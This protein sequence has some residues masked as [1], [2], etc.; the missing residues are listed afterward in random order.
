VSSE[1]IHNGAPSTTAG[2]EQQM[3]SASAGSPRLSMG[4]RIAYAVGGVPALIEQRG[5]SAFLLIFY[6]QVVG[7][8][9]YLVTSALLVTAIVDALCDP[10]VGQVSDNLHSRWGRRHPFIYA[11]FIPLSLGYLLIWCPPAHWSQSMVFAY[12]L[13]MLL[14]VR[15]ADSCYE[16]PA[17]ALLPELTR[18]YNER[19]GI[20][21]L[22]M[23]FALIGGMSMTML[24]YRVF[25]KEDAHGAGGIL[26]RHGY[27]GYGVASA[28][29]IAVT[30]VISGIGTHRRIPFLSKPGRR[31]AT[32]GTMMREVGTTISNRSFLALIVAGI[33]MSTC[34][35]AK[36][37]LDIYFGL[38]FWDLQQGQLANLVVASLIGIVSGVLLAPPLARRFG[39][40][41]AA[42]GV[43]IA[44]IIGNG[45]PVLG[46]LFGLMPPNHSNALFVILFADGAFTF[47]V[48]T[49]TTILM[50]SMLNDVVEDVEVKTGRRS[51]GLLMAADTLCRKLVSSLGIFI[52]GLMLT[53]IG[54]P[55]K[56]AR[57]SVAP[58]LVG[59]LAY[60]YILMTVLF[61][62][63]LCM[64]YF[65]R[66]N[67]TTHEQNLGVLRQR[68]RE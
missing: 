45:G 35:G 42:V 17:S 49:A 62:I 15:V 61:I 60:A 51:E 33:L 10:L 13:A 9:P 44:G 36:T 12:L 24:A 63:A 64:L 47:C 58:E 11:S 46:R 6:N 4:T 7:L 14:I 38:Y 22:R 66:I 26:A 65:Y 32:L 1:L 3:S 39:K 68:A 20:L 21:S 16:L 2:D 53:L 67:R 31:S 29:V 34:N 40:R 54:F 59:K 52:S 57:G 25:L 48:A 30:I 50:T 28:V 8:P 55:R 18:N 56:A 41:P 19:T 43:I 27:F 23:L 5:L 37:G